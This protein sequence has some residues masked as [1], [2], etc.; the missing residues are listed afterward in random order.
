MKKLLGLTLGIMT[1]LGGFVDFGQIVFTMQA[2]A[3]FN[4]RLVWAIALGT[5][6]IIVYM[7]MCGRVAVVAKEPVFAVI[8]DRLGARLGLIVL[9]ASNL[10]NVITCAAEL[11]GIAIVL[12]LLTGWPARAVLIAAAAVL[13]ATIQALRFEW[14]ERIFGLAGL[15]MIVFAV[16]AAFLHPDWNA[17]G[18]GL[19]PRSAPAGPH[20]TLLYYYFAVGIF[21]AMLMVYEVH[22]YSSGAMEEDWTPADLKENFLVACFGSVL[23]ALL[24]IA[25]LVLGALV[26]LP[27]GIYPRLLSTAIL[28]GSLP[29][30]KRGLLLA[31][32]GTMACLGGA[33]VE[34]ALSGAYNVCQFYNL[35]WGKN[36]PARKVRMFTQCWIGMLVLAMLLVLSGL[37][38]LQLVNV[39]VIFGMVLMPLTYYPILRVAMD[40]NIMGEHVNSRADTAIGAT[41]LALIAVAAA[42]AIPLMIATDS[43][44]P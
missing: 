4:Y 35:P 19:L 15:L 29:F 34:T 12:H 27:R 6:A 37:S 1:A 9:I 41:I 11:G 28:T 30:G 43:G 25:L 42:A 14:M 22:F 21:S 18:R 38:P 36:V 33:A 44:R 13:V 3:L 40:R 16:S 17:V 31:A 26:F 39:S 10:L 8:R 32:A 5:V 20:Q 7:E 24:T 23:G 2:G